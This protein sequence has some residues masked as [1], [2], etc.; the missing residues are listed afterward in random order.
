MAGYTGRIKRKVSGSPKDSCR[1]GINARVVSDSLSIAAMQ[2]ACGTHARGFRLFG[3]RV[4]E[5]A[6]APY[7]SYADFSS[8]I[9]NYYLSDWVFTCGKR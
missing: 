3:N 7:A 2:G 1:A 4:R 5:F 8:L 9:Y 6:Y